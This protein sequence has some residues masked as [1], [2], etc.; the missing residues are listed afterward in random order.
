MHPVNTLDV[1]IEIVGSTDTKVFLQS[2]N[3]LL[4]RLLKFDFGSIL[5]GPVVYR[6]DH[7]SS[8]GEL[9]ARGWVRGVQAHYHWAI[10]HN[11]IIEVGKHVDSAAQRRLGVGV[12]VWANVHFGIYPGETG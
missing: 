4:S 3:K 10:L 1:S 5:Y 8:G 9:R 11:S 12:G 7:R 2:G 6:I